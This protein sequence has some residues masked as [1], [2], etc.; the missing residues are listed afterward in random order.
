MRI[1]ALEPQQR[2]SFQYIGSIISK[3]GEIKEKVELRSWMIEVE[4]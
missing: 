1:E 2:E 4:T 3:D